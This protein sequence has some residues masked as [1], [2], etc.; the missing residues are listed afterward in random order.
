MEGSLVELTGLEIQIATALRRFKER[1]RRGM[2][3][4]KLFAH[5]YGPVLRLA[6]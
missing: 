3:H 2:H 4:R 1:Y 5:K 6:L